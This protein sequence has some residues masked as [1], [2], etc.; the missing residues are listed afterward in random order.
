MIIG[1]GYE[2]RVCGDVHPCA[3]RM[4]PSNW[5]WLVVGFCAHITKVESMLRISVVTFILRLP[6]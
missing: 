3:C 1:P 5:L 4:V 6:I 2:S